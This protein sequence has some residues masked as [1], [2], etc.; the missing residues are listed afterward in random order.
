MGTPYGWPCISAIAAECLLALTLLVSPAYPSDLSSNVRLV[1][2]KSNG[3]AIGS[4]SYL[5]NGYFLTANHVA[6]SK[7]P[8]AAF[9]SNGDFFAVKVIARDE[10]LDIAVLH[11]PTPGDVTPVSVDCRFPPLGEELQFTGQPKGFSFLTV[12]SRVAKETSAS[13]TWPS[14]MTMDGFSYEGM[15]GA[16]GL[17]KAG[18]L[19]AVMVGNTTVYLAHGM[20]KAPL[21]LGWAV[22]AAAFCPLL[23]Q[24]GALE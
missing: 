17:D 6:P 4:G 9:A 18:R 21:P 2:T 19:V 16:G 15:S 22:P 7:D 14:V 24:A 12:W 1:V 11:T 23:K 13:D 8:I 20:N 5:G 3:D 10:K